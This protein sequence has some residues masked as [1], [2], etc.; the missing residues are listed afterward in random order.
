MP[1]SPE[2]SEMSKAMYEFIHGIRR[3][4]QTLRKPSEKT[5]P[6]AAGAEKPKSDSE[7]MLQE[8]SETLKR[9]SVT[10]DVYTILMTRAEHAVEFREIRL[11]D[12]EDTAKRKDLTDL[13]KLLMCDGVLLRGLMRDVY[14]LI[15]DDVRKHYRDQSRIIYRP[16]VVAFVIFLAKL[17]T[18]GRCSDIVDFWMDHNIGVQLLVPGM[19]S[20]KHMIS[21]ETVRT[22]LCMCGDSI[23]EKVFRKFFAK[24]AEQFRTMFLNK[25]NVRDGYRTTLGWDG[26]EFAASYRSGESDRKMKGAL[27]TTLFDCTNRTVKGFEVSQSKNHESEDLITILKRIGVDRTA[28]YVADAINFKAKVI[29]FLDR[30]GCDRMLSLKA[31]NKIMYSQV[32]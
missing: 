14:D 15:F 6:A 21:E 10:R 3:R 17:S 20:P 27:G 4:W 18:L 23:A 12:A 32:K 16:E 26:Q 5:E 8:Y 13:E 2:K 7:A 29:N 22:V 30:C 25:K 1:H 19:P 24:V 28:V 11:K 9:C 31:S